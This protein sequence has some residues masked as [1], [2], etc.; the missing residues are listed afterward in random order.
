TGSSEQGARTQQGAE[1][2]ANPGAW[3]TWLVGTNFHSPGVQ[4]LA[5][6]SEHPLGAPWRVL[7]ILPP[8]AGSQLWVGVCLHRL[9]SHVVSGSF[10]TWIA[11][12]E[13]GGSWDLAGG[14][15][16]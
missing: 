16:F 7:E 9:P 5:T 15:L 13:V 11:A 3:R 14:P 12:A 10:S 6:E 1:A 4:F 2:A 8:S